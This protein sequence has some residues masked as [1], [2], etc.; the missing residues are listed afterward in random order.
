MV[1][2]WKHK[3][4][5][6]YFHTSSLNLNVNI[7]LQIY[8]LLHKRDTPIILAIKTSSVI[9]NINFLKYHIFLFIKFILCSTSQRVF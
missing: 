7:N 9:I 4:F 8:F 5:I 1:E 2:L 6:N 3:G